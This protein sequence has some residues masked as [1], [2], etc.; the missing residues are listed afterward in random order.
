MGSRK[1]K[2]GFPVFV[3][4]KFVFGRGISNVISDLV[5]YLI[6]WKLKQVIN[7]DGT[8]S[9]QYLKTLVSMPFQ[10]LGANLIF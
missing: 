9:F 5:L 7:N 2:A 10:E 4:G 1:D 6:E 8:I 3:F